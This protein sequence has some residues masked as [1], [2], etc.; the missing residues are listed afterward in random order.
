MT[1]A[2]L[3]LMIAAP[4]ASATRTSLSISWPW[5]KAGAAFRSARVVTVIAVAPDRAG[6]SARVVTGRNAL[7]PG[8]SGA[9]WAAA[10]ARI[11]AAAMGAWC[12]SRAPQNQPRSNSTVGAAS[13]AIA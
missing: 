8:A 12:M 11:S 2:K 13:S 10:A 6:V 9:A 3:W 7:S 1:R 4:S 5:M